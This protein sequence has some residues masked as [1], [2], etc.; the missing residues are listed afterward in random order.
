MKN[1][2]RRMIIRICGIDNWI[3][4]E[5]RIAFWKDAELKNIL[6]EN[7]DIKNR[8]EG[9]RCFILGNGPSL[10]N[11]DFSLLRDEFVFT[12]NQLPRN[13]RFKELHTNVHVWVD[14]RFFNIDEKKPEDMELLDV[15][16]NVK[17]EENNPIVFYHYI[18]K[19]MV[20]KFKLDKYLNI[21]Y[22]DQTYID[23]KDI[24]NSSI[25]YTK[26]VPGFGTVVHYI[27]CLAVYMGFSEIV[28]LGCDCSGF[29]SI[30]KARLGKAENS[31][32]S[33]EISE[34]E[35]NRMEKLQSLTSIRDELF[36]Q[37]KLF[38]DYIVLN[39]YCK[40][41]GVELYN[42]TYPTLLEGVEKIDLE[43]FLMN[44]VNC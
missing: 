1:A 22:F 35:K 4:L 9:R 6:A 11:V 18:A 12:V 34:N 16:K 31:L 5:S 32:Y 20:E 44:H 27:I 38:D 19:P 37:V 23:S 39:Q 25:D 3:K 7:A 30:A 2:M 33:Y 15:M 10:K 21:R 17:D 29:V 36:W 8:Y 14:R 41:H 13:P 43:Q 26:L 28:L 42:A 24:L 40:N